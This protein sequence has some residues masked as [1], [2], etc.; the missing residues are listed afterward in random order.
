MRQFLILALLSLCFI[1][2]RKKEDEHSA[3]GVDFTSYQR[4]DL[5]ANYLGTEGNATDD[6]KMEEWPQ[7]VFDLFTPLDTVNLTGYRQ[8]G[9][10]IDALYPNPCADTQVMRLAATQPINLKMVM[11]DV[12]KNVLFRKSFHV[13]NAIQFLGFD[14]KPLNLP[15]AFYRMFYSFSAEDKPHFMRGHI[16][17]HKIQ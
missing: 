14:Y 6:Y 12:N 9:I 10:S 3:A 1:S 17:I 7:W 5:N 15:P 2:C 16:D 13:P 8:S 11:I 4:F